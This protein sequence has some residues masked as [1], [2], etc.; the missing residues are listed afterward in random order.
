MFISHD[1]RSW[2][3]LCA[4]VCVVL[5]AHLVVWTT[6]QVVASIM[7]DVYVFVLLG[8][9]YLISMIALHPLV[10]GADLKLGTKIWVKFK[11][12]FGILIEYSGLNMSFLPHSIY[13]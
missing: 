9:L 12:G 8:Q 5:E 10:G 2:Y 6:M 4:C 13:A 3:Y 1:S 11:V 7:A